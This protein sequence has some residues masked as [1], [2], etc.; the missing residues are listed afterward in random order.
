[1]LRNLLLNICEFNPKC[2]FPKRTLKFVS[3]NN[4][5]QEI[6]KEKGK[7]KSQKDGQHGHENID[8]FLFR[9]RR[10]KQTKPMLLVFYSRD[11]KDRP[12][13]NLTKY[14]SFIFLKK[15]PP[16]FNSIIN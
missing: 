1:M 3:K 14:N 13:N 10:R 7:E 5:K 12:H 11:E 16:F 8:R 9:K 2:S 4:L 15:T 6:K